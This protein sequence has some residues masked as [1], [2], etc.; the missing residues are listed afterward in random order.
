M[1]LLSQGKHNLNVTITNN[2]YDDLCRLI[3]WGLRG[4]VFNILINQLVE[5]LKQ[6]GIEGLGRVLSGQLTVS[7][8]MA[9]RKDGTLYK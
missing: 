3:P 1:S 4:P 2:Q 8:V 9:I 5:I 7:D 6:V